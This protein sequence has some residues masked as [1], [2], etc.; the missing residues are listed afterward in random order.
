MS[1]IIGIEFFAVITVIELF[2]GITSILCHVLE[3]FLCYALERKH[4]KRQAVMLRN[5]I[6]SVNEIYTSRFNCIE[7]CL[8]L[9]NNKQNEITDLFE[10]ESLDYLSYE[11]L[12]K[13][14]TDHIESIKAVTRMQQSK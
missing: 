13:K 1:I 3:P 6:T 7:R 14:I 8:Q 2:A 4:K 9:L 10:K 12:A 5:Q 11:V